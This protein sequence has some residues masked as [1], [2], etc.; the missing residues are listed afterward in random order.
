MLVF[1]YAEPILMEVSNKYDIEEVELITNELGFHTIENY[2]D[3]KHWY[4][5]TL[6][7]K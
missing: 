4:L 1:R 6:L 5:N 7:K 2:L 3:C